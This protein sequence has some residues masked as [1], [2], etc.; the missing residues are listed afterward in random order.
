MR[1]VAV[2][3]IVNFLINHVA[4]PKYADFLR[5]VILYGIAELEERRVMSE[6]TMRDIEAL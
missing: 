1:D 5:I 4:S 3:K 2:W 6:T